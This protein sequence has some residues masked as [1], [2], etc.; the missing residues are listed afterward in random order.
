MYH[1]NNSEISNDLVTQ[2]DDFRFDCII[3][4][5]MTFYVGHHS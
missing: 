4:N 2:S 5:S 3:R 1:K